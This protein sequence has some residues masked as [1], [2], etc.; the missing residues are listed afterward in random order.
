MKAFDDRLDFSVGEQRVIGRQ[1][2]ALVQNRM[3]I[4]NA[5]FRA[6]ML[7]RTT[8]S[9][10]VRQLQTNYQPIV[11]AGCLN[12]L[13]PQNVT[14]VREVF[15]CSGSGEK[16]VGV[17]TSFVGNRNGF[18]APNQLA[19]AAAEPLPPANGFFRRG[20][21]R[22][23]VPTLHRLNCDSVADFERT[24]VQRRAQRGL[25]SDRDVGIAG[26]MQPEGLQVT[27]KSSNTVEGPQAN[28]C[29]AAH[30]ALRRAGKAKTARPPNNA[31]PTRTRQPSV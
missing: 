22:S 23:R 31:I 27:L 8:V 21:V 4:E 6:G 16:L 24:A 7:I 10:G 17:R 30:G 26:D 18:S 25:A 14:Q 19:A 13:A 28:D 2:Q 12:M 9:A 3:V 1:L 20:A 5:G 29:S 11:A 15:L